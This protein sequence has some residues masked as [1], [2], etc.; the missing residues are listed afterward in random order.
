MNLK[1]R[2]RRLK[3][4]IP[5]VFI[6]LKD[7]ETPWYAKF[8]AAITVGYALSPIDF[9]PDF[10]PVLG[11]L[12]DVLILPALVALT[13][14]AI[15]EHIWERSRRQS[16]NMWVSGKPKRWYYAIPIVAIWLIII[17]LIIKWIW[18]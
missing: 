13:V 15:P 12:D 3:A 16:E 7:R 1:E 6:A 9:I 5:A 17:W 4:D 18:L 8:L 10:I 11:Y 2:A 14:R